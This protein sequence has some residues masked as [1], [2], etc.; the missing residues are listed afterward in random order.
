MS[1]VIIRLDF[2]INLVRGRTTMAYST[3]LR[4]Q[5]IKSYEAGKH[6]QQDI[7]DIL[8]MHLS[9]FKRIYKQ[10]RETGSVELPKSNAGR[11]GLI[12]DDGFAKIKG[13]VES[14]PD[15]T[16]E[17][18]QTAYENET[19]VT[20]SIST[21]CRALQRL[22][23][24]RKKISH[25]AQEQEREDVKKKRKNYRKESKKIKAEHLVFIDESGVNLKQSSRYAR[26]FKGNR[27]KLPTPFSRGKTYSM[28]GAVTIN[29]VLAAMYGEWATNT[30]IFE[31]FVEY[32]L[33]PVLTPEHVVV[34]DN[35][36]F[37]HNNDIK[38]KIESTGARLMYL[39]PYSPDFSPIENM[40]SKIKTCLRKLAARTE[41]ELQ[42]AMATA[43]KSINSSDLAGWFQ[44][45]GYQIDQ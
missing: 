29:D 1:R 3:N 6:T 23:F 39:P 22:S 10:Y 41:K 11:P 42:L 2:Q 34:M 4:L 30:E 27:V 12:D 7:A 21:I 24:N 44:H 9:T 20:L 28:I 31:H 15:I 43:F 17:A 25:Y 8:G 40:W 36:S 18:I 37:H 32:C 33:C 26:A 5:A 35:I 16:L 13:Y 45:C 19:K 14:N 38:H